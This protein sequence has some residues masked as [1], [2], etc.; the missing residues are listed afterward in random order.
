MPLSVHKISLTH[1]RNYETL[2]LEPRGAGMIVLTGENGAGKTNILEAVSLLA[3]GK[4]LRGAALDDILDRKAESF[5][6]WA[7]AADIETAA[8][9]RAK[10]GTGLAAGKQ[11]PETRRRVVR[12]D[13]KDARSQNDLAKL[14]S[15]VWLTPQ[16]DRLFLEGGTVRRKFLDR[17]VF[18]FDPAHA[19]HLNR[20]EKNL[21]ERMRLLQGDERTARMGPDPR[22]L[23]EL[24]SQLAADGVA[25]AAAR[26][27][28]I[29]RLQHHVLKDSGFPAPL[30]ELHGW[31]DAQITS[32]AALDIEDE[33]KQRLQKSRPADSVSGKSQEGPH[34][35]DFSVIYQVKDMPAAQCSTGEQ[36][37]L[38]VSTVL[39]HATMMKAEKGFVPILLLDEVAA[40]LDD[41]RRAELFDYLASFDAQVWLTGTESAVFTGLE[42]RALFFRV[43]D[44]R[45]TEQ[46]LRAVS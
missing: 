23:A 24:E 40:H 15:V 43:G 10:I 34:R 41:T 17:L 8:G 21:R 3:P 6:A 2:R 42:N 13:G 29:D 1:F 20:Y 28:L 16:M 22:W 14:V 32:R 25:I 27:D 5:D 45:V 44:N 19:T 38:L 26:R 31:L 4:G 7:I 37:G 11:N 35:S 33:L 39:A 12:I 36:K 46:A 30:F 18:A 9:E